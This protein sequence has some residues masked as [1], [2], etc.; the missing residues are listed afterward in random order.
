MAHLEDKILSANQHA[1]RK[2]YSTVTS[3]AELTNK[4][5]TYLDN[6]L[7]VGLASM[8]LSKAFDSICHT[9]LLQK[10]SKMGLHGNTVS[11]IESYLHSRKQK[12]SFKHITS[13]ENEVTSGVPQGSIMGPI[14]FLC[15]TNDLINAFPEET[16]ISYADDSQFVVTGKSMKQIKCKL[17]NVIK[18][19]E[20]W[21]KE[22]SLM[23]NPSKTEIMI[24]TP[25]MRNNPTT[26]EIVIHENGRAIKLEAR[27]SIKILG[28][29]VDRHMN[30][31]EHITNLRNKT[32]GIVR[33]LHRVNKLLPLKVKL[34]L[35]DSLV[36]SHV[37][38]ADIIWAGCNTA[39][40]Q[41]L[42][43]VQ[44]FALKSILG[45]RKFDS[46][47]EAL[48]KLKYLNLE[49]KRK[50]H[51]GVFT[52]KALNKKMPKNIIEEY[53]KLQSYGSNRSAMNGSLKIP[54]HKTA[55]YENSVLYRTVNVWNKTEVTT[56]TDSTETFKKK[57]QG[58]YTYEKFMI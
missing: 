28:I 13:A 23:S 44:N 37:N 55:R 18:K 16:V 57:L 26:P 58:S 9:Y 5:Y 11:W 45:M 36:A 47:T 40:K 53:K 27:E 4:I 19:A 32:I 6:G 38:Y 54:M 3:L 35:Y 48:T 39:S 42:Q 34:Q 7:I 21:Y 22:N 14:L 46:A 50:A 10:L 41:K 1:Y 29:Q 25:S 49:E 24:L 56:R 2:F 51:E 31:N 12:T 33:H 15:F 17:E 8:D 30:W 52:H 43:H 20:E